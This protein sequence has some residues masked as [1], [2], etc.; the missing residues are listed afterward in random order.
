M[1][2]C[3]SVIGDRSLAH[4]HLE[5]VTRTAISLSVARVTSAEANTS[6]GKAISAKG[7]SWQRSTYTTRY[8]TSKRFKKSQNYCSTGDRKTEYSLILNTL[9]PLN[10][11]NICVTNPTSMVGLQLRNL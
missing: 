7:N 4:I 10:L 9:I 6:N 8:H 3:L 5:H 2:I 11:S 1:E